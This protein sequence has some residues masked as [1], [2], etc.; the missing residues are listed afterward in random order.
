M[1]KKVAL[2]GA[3]GSIGKSSLDVLRKGEFEPVLF[4][5]RT[6]YQTLAALKKE[7]PQAL[8]ALTDA[9][10]SPPVDYSGP[11][12]LLEAIKNCGADIIINGISGAA[13]LEPSLA[14]I[15]TGCRLALANKET[16]VMA[17][18][19][20][21]SR[22]KETN[23]QIIP[24]DSEHSAVFLLLQAHGKENIE[25]IILT[26]S[27]GP[28][29]NFTMTQLEKV[30]PAEALAHPTWN[31]GPKI[32]IDSATLANKGLEVI[33]AAGLFGLPLQKIK[34]LIHPQSIVHSM[35]RLKNGTLYAQLSNPDMR[36]PIHNAL[37]WPEI[38]S[39]S[40]GA[41]DFNGLSLDF[42]EPD[43]ERFPMLSL[44][45]N[46]CEK[47]PL[48]PAV[49]NAANEIAA[50]SFLEGKIPFLEI[51]RITG[52]VLDNIVVPEKKNPDLDDI[53]GID[54]KARDLARQTIGSA[55]SDIG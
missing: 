15:D 33:E 30:L 52:Y 24:V 13:G 44:A 27:G 6:N 3:T 23:A 42:S 37:Y 7:F 19:L 22:A 17:G 8:L 46:A 40:F 39:S 1:K 45:Y 31:M 47:G 25:E 4:S 50:G 48:F 29:R 5:A 11:G 35:V 26:A 14:A 9:A 21:L 34:V 16:I 2:L 28:F 55:E 41:L 32:T 10:G 36:N 38:P 18:S 51:P 54:Q 49:Y 43:F 20:V 53:A 12:G